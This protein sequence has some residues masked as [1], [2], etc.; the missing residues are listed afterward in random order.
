MV[1]ANTDGSLTISRYPP[2]DT[3]GPDPGPATAAPGPNP[4]FSKISRTDV[5]R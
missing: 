4:T 2:Q 3:T 1:L 5:C